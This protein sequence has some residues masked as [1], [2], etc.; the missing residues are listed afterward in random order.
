MALYLLSG[1]PGAGKSTLLTALG[2]AGFAV[3]EEVS[4]QLIQEQVALGSRQVPWLD[5]AGFAELAL[6]RMVTQHRQA[7]LRGGVTFFDRGLPDLIAYLEVAGQSVPPAYYAAVAAHPYR[8]LVFLAPPWPEIYVNDAERWQTFDEATA[9]Y[10]ALHLV[11]QRVGYTVVE[12]PRTS[13]AARVSFVRTV[14]GI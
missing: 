9:I 6:A 1:G 7:T 13:V 12:L 2:H 4:R 10:R 5:L 14:A 8:P 3:A 11:Y